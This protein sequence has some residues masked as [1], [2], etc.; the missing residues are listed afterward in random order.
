MS[1]VQ[2]R[3]RPYFNME[4]KKFSLYQIPFDGFYGYFFTLNSQGFGVIK[5]GP[6]DSCAFHSLSN[7]EAEFRRQK[8]NFDIE[9]IPAKGQEFSGMGRYTL[10][11]LFD[12]S[13]YVENGELF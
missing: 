1:A 11:Y 4:Y 5:Y 3:H 12:E 7:L 8:K 10:Q 9:I 13:L 2:A 6:N